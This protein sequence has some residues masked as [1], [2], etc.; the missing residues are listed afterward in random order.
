MIAAV[1]IDDRNGLLFNGRRLS[2]DKAQQEDLLTLCGEK[3]LW[4]SPFSEKLLDW[5]AER[6]LVDPAYLAKAGQG[7]ICFVEA[8]TLADTERLEGLILYRWNRAYPS[9][10]KLEADLDAFELTERVEFP[11]SSHETITRETYRK[12]V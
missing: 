10:R 8:D 7:E 12:K 3:R 4:V 6:L 5:A 1:C 2:R 9:D 11:G